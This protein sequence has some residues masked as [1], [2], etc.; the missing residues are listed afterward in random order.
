MIASWMMK[1]KRMALRMIASH[2]GEMGAHTKWR[3]AGFCYQEKQRWPAGSEHGGNS[4]SGRTKA[5]VRNVSLVSVHSVS[6]GWATPWRSV[7]SDLWQ[8]PWITGQRRHC[9]KPAC[10]TQRL[11]R[12]DRYEKKGKKKRWQLLPMF[13]LAK[14]FI[15]AVKLCWSISRVSLRGL[16]W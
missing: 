16:E 7:I 8:S 15:S 9:I 6:L 13:H 5:S 1:L 2:T 10:L 11:W 14:R 3:S 12:L 4:L